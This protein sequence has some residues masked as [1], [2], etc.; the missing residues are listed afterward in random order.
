MTNKDKFLTKYCRIKDENPEIALQLNGRYLHDGY[1]ITEI[2]PKLMVNINYE[3]CNSL[4]FRSDEFLKSHDGKHILF[5]GCSETFGEGGSLEDVWAKKLY[6]KINGITKTSG[7]FN[8]GVPGFSVSDIIATVIEYIDNYGNPDLI[9]INF[10]TLEREVG[11][12]LSDDMKEYGLEIFNNNLKYM[13][14]RFFQHNFKNKKALSGKY[15]KVIND[16]PSFLS[17]HSKLLNIKLLESLCKYNNIKLIWTTWER[18]FHDLIIETNIPFSDYHPLINFNKQD[19][20]IFELIEKNKKYSIRKEDG[21]YGTAHHEIWSTNLF[22]KYI[23][24]GYNV[25]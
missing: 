13:W 16:N 8:I 22:D 12:L 9:F 6:N 1:N 14:V 4:G 23:S 24:L 15:F 21:H 3:G 7:F 19:E 17:Y 20:L 25:L 5:A 2:F 18:L 11:L 10:P